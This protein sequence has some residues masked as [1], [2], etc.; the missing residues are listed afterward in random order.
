MNEPNEPVSAERWKLRLYIAGQTPK[1]LT[2][3]AN[4]KAICEEHLSGRYEIELVDLLE[5]PGLAKAHQILGIPTL[6]R[7][8]PDPMRKIIGDLSN[9]TLV[10]TM[11]NIPLMNPLKSKEAR[12]K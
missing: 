10:V 11:L 2:A 8:E 9:K 4:L 7:L 6:V 12:E 3:F 1:S 5:T